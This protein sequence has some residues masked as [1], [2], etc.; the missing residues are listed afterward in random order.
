MQLEINKNE[1]EIL[2]QAL[3]SWQE[4]PNRDSLGKTMFATLLIRDEDA[5]KRMSEKIFTEAG[6]KTKLREQQVLMLRS[7]INQQIAKASEHELLG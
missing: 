4:E 3:K 1:L 7:R 5:A 6:E 2:E